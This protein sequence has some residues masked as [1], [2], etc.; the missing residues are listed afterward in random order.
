MGFINGGTNKEK[1][2]IISNLLK[3]MVC[4]NEG[5]IKILE[6]INNNKLRKSE[7]ISNDKETILKIL[8]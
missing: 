6:V 5:T 3:R 2:K 4:K 8:E 1:N 7:I